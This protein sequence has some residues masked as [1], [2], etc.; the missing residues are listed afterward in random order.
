MPVNIK[1]LNTREVRFVDIEPDHAG[2]RIDNY[3]M[4]ELKGLPRSRVYRLLR[5]GEVRINGRRVKPATRLSVGD[6][7]RIPPVRLPPESESRSFYIENNIE[8]TIIYESNVMLILNKP[9]GMAVHGGSQLAA[10]V[11]ESLRRVRPRDRT[12]ELVHR[13]DRGTSGCLMVA[14]KRS[15]LKLLQAELHR[16]ERLKKGYLAIVHGAWPARRQEINAPIQ[17]V[18][19]KSGERFCRVDSQG[20]PS[21]TRFR[22][23]GRG[24]GLS[25]LEVIPVTGRTHQIRVH[26]RFAGSPVVGD[27]RYGRE[28][29]DQPW[30]D[31]GFNRLMLHAQRLE[32]PALG[33]HPAVSVE[34]PLDEPMRNLMNIV[35]TVQKQ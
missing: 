22:V 17:R 29:Q 30:R 21:L 25:A 26:C 16:K 12:L 15:Y 1:E 19:H 8:K 31:R 24:N 11:I 34:A 13:L 3:L 32:I 20:K 6:R 10:G 23:I 7:L 35:D 18:V 2:Q 9:S 4:R 5:K 28:S 27:D 33:E 14:R